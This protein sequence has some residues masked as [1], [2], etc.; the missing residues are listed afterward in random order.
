MI[1]KEFLIKTDRGGYKAVIWRDKK[2]RAFLVKVPSLPG[3]VTYG[4]N[5]AEAKRMA[6]DAI[7]LHLYRFTAAGICRGG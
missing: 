5:L 4:E 2:D 1:K 6:K 7:E 3:V